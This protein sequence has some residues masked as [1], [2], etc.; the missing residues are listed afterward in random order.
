VIRGIKLK[1]MLEQAQTVGFV[2]PGAP[3]GTPPEKGYKAFRKQ[4]RFALGLAENFQTGEPC[5]NL[6]DRV[7]NAKEVDLAE[8]CH[9][10]MPEDFRNGNA[11]R[12]ALNMPSRLRLQE[13]EGG[14]VGAS[15]FAHVS[16]FSDTVGGLIE[17]LV[18][19]AY[20]NP[21]Y[22]GDEFFVTKTARVQGGYAIGVRMD[23]GVS[24]NPTLGEPYPTVGLNETRVRIPENI[25]NGIAIQLREDA[26]IYDRTDQI[27]AMA[28]NAGESVRRKKELRQADCV[29]GKTNTYFRD[30]VASNTYRTA[31]L[32]TVG[33]NKTTPMH[34]INAQTGLPLT[35]WHDWNVAKQILSRNT[36]PATGWEIQVRPQESIMLVSPDNELLTQTIINATTLQTRTTSPTATQATAVSLDVRN[37]S[38]PLAEY[39]IRIMSSRLWYN[40]LLLAGTDCADGHT[41]ALDATLTLGDEATKAQSAWLWGAFKRCFQYRQIIPFETM[42]APLSSEDVRRDIV[43]IYVSREWGVPWALEPRYVFQGANTYTV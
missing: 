11:I 22:I 28:S 12:E 9:T 19:E 21:D 41:G 31:V 10:L 25:R 8:V 42:Q 13:A 30:N 18:L 34:Y 26:F 1:K 36:D 20:Q 2:P 33:E 37:H 14:V 16:A 32:D 38:N 3:Q 27:Q 24:D 15:Q 4:L 7:L 17:A 23:G 40:R 43:A 35:D 6:N 5:I 29:L 39:G